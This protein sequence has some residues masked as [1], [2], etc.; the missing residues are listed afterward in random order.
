MTE[1][2]PSGP[3]LIVVW[4]MCHRLDKAVNLLS[5][6][7]GSASLIRLMEDSMMN[8]SWILPKSQLVAGEGLSPRRDRTCSKAEGRRPGA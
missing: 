8:D 2:E 3:G 4:R 1:G 6:I 7:I 5:L